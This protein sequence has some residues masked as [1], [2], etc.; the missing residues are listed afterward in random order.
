MSQRGG[1]LSARQIENRVKY[2]AQRAG[3]NIDLHPTFIKTLF[4]QSFT[5]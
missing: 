4:C 1:R 2:Q 3:V 5:L